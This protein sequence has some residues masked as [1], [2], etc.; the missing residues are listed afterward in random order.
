[1]ALASV[2]LLRCGGESAPG[3]EARG[4]PSGRAGQSGTPTG[5]AGSGGAAGSAKG[6]GAG[7]PQ[8]GGGGSSG[9]PPVTNSGGAEAG[10]TQASGRGGDAGAHAAA[11]ARASS[12]GHDF[13]TGAESGAGGEA[14][15][16]QNTCPP[17]LDASM[18]GVVH[19]A[20]YA[21]ANTSLYRYVG[22]YLTGD[23]P[24]YRGSATIADS[25]QQLTLDSTDVIAAAVVE[26][27]SSGSW[28][29]LTVVDT[30]AR[31]HGTFTQENGDPSV[32]YAESI[33]PVGTYAVGGVASCTACA[34]DFYHAP[35][36]IALPSFDAHHAADDPAGGGEPTFDITA[37]LDLMLVAPSTLSWDDL[38]ALNV[39]FLSFTQIG[40]DMVLHQ[41]G[42]VTL[43]EGSYKRC[44]GQSVDYTIDLYVNLANPLDYGLRNFV[45]G[46]CSPECGP[47]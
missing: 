32:T 6:A 13:G 41:H 39:G 44:D 40:G 30:Q 4:D 35:D 7:S 10:G 2:F 11:G 42:S 47:A 20:A 29:I 21:A 34:P 37:T 46:A 22:R 36:T 8:L 19:D 12:G 38:L 23:A 1:M 33:Y 14:G 28:G 31:T 26:V 43:V 17:E 5:D 16:P 18:L 3:S 24:V 9:K 27:Q 15:G 45:A 25:H